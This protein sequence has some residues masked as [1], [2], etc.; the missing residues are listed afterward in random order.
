MIANGFEGR[1]EDL[2]NAEDYGFVNVLD[3]I[4]LNLSNELLPNTN[5]KCQR[6]VPSTGSTRESRCSHRMEVSFRRMSTPSPSTLITDLV[7]CH[8]LIV[9]HFG[10]ITTLTLSGEVGEVEVT[11]DDD[12]DVVV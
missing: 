2:W 11:I 12:G 10:I 6:N 8:C 4:C 5:T 9:H 7:L 1:V 3:Y